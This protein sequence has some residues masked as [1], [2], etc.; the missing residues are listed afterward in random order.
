MI[1]GT[2]SQSNSKDEVLIV[3]LKVWSENFAK[4]T[5]INIGANKIAVEPA[6][7]KNGKISNPNKIPKRDKIFPVTKNCIII[8]AA[9]ATE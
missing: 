3:N 8:D 1:G 9:P 4:L 7:K 6:I 2:G 5:L